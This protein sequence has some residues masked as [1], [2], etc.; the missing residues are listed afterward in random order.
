MAAGELSTAGATDTAD[1][2][3]ELGISCISMPASC[4]GFCSS[5]YRYVSA[6]TCRLYSSEYG[7][8]D[9]EA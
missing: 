6:G 2:P 3:W 7:G 1:V 5:W 4:A 8:A 9:F